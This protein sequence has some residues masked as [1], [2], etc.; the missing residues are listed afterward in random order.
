MAATGLK[1]F[2][3][4]PVRAG[5]ESGP[6]SA[7]IDR[8]VILI[9]L[10]LGSIQTAAV[11]SVESVGSDSSVY[12]VLAHNLRETGHYE[13]NYQ[14]HTVYPP[15]FPLLLAL[16]GALV[17][18]EGYGIFVRLMP[19]FSTMALIVWYLVLKRDEGRLVAGACC[20]LLATSAPLMKLVTRTV[21]SEPPFFLMSGVALWCLLRL[22]RDEIPSRALRRVLLTLFCAAT[23][24]AVLLRSAGVALCAAMLA[25][26][27]TETGFNRIHRY[28]PIV[29]ATLIAAGVGLA[30][31]V[32]WT[33]WSLLAETKE[34]PSQRMASYASQFLTADLH[35]PES[36]AASGVDFVRRVVT[37]VPVQ[38][39]HI[40]AL[41]ARAPY[42]LPTWYSPGVVIAIG[43]LTCGLAWRIYTG[44]GALLA[45]YFLCYF[46]VYLLW[47]FDEGPRFMLPVAP[48]AFVLMWRGVL[49]LAALARRRPAATLG[50]IAWVAAILSVA[51]AAAERLPGWQDR[52]SV[53]FWPLA[54]TAFGLAWLLV[55]RGTTGGAGAGFR[56]VVACASSGQRVRYG[57]IG[58][59]IV[60]MGIGVVQ[61]APGALSNLNPDQSAFVHHP[62]ADLA[63]W[64]ESAPEGTVMAQQAA[65]IHRLSGRRVVSFPITTNPQVIRETA[66]GE[67]VRYIAVNDRCQSEY[68]SPAE[69]DRWEKVEQAYPGMF[70]LVRKGVGHRVFERV[71]NTNAHKGVTHW[72]RAGQGGESALP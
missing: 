38:V 59:L 58:A 31:F 9:L 28:Q 62:S 18:S 13:F 8:I 47:P 51:A 42:L 66:A 46:G 35:G 26:V 50:T 15:G 72:S 24:S 16:I 1:T 69:E 45:W 53:V 44:Q 33:V 17:G 14:P 64:L 52:A 4:A 12:M 25:W 23:A 40:V 5:D 11:Q 3:F 56:A 55:R 6:D 65:I 30:F 48:L 63:Q 43:L 36:V 37:N 19:V 34:Y 10:I 68:F 57:L 71:N 41:A 21:L 61:Q 39:A 2:V 27:V 32:A 29:R 7:S 67:N 70:R 60:L 49:V 54:A 22:K 20:L